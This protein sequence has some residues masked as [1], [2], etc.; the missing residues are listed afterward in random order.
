[1]VDEP[2]RP[3]ARSDRPVEP[4]ERLALLDA[5]RGFAL[6]GVL[7][8]NLRAFCLYDDLDEAA[9]ARLPSAALDRY[10][11]V[12]F[13][14]LVDGK[15]FTLFCL[16]FG[17][18]FALQTRQVDV[19]PAAGRRYLRRMLVLLA[20]GV[21]HALIW[22]GDILRY[23][24]VLGLVLLPLARFSARTLAIA[25]V[26][27]ALFA[28]PLLRD[29]IAPWLKP[30]INGR[31]ARDLVLP[32][33]QGSD[34]REVLSANADFAAYMFRA[35]WS[36]V[37]VVLGRLLVGAALGRSNMLIDPQRHRR[38]WRGLLLGGLAIG[39]ALTAFLLLRRH[40]LAFTGDI[41]T[42]TAG[43]LFVRASL[44]ASS[45]ALGLG[46]LAAF[47]LL[48]QH[49]AGRRL[50]QP[51]APIG[52]MALSNYLTQ[53][54]IGIGL[55]YGIGAGLGA[56]FGLAGTV[57]ACAGIFLLQA[58][59]S[60]IWLARYRYGPVEWLWRALTYGRR[61]AFQRTASAA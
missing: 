31:E 19:D 38:F 46:Y 20:I 8:V 15:A 26:L 43:R 58:H 10:F 5:L 34:L 40:D 24:A 48:F 39:V 25:G 14:L 1:M 44:G 9:L 52:R 61:P 47:V 55:F 3:V 11:E 7:L 45:L 49:P 32:A 50:L 4:G 2:A 35:N 57:V 53:T 27:I 29:W 42:S 59:M 51:F 60:R 22:W 36:L 28:A 23:Y 56:R 16:L 13:S 54:L 33:F 12:L 41:W 18:G 21:L 6:I 37:F 30:P 17:V